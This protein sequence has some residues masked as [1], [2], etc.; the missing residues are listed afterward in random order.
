MNSIWSI[1]SAYLLTDM[2]VPKGQIHNLSGLYALCMSAK[3][4]LLTP[5]FC[6]SKWW[7]N[8][9][10]D[11]LADII[12]IFQQSCA[13]ILNLQYGRP[14]CVICWMKSWTD[15]HAGSRIQ[16]QLMSLKVE[17]RDINLWYKALRMTMMMHS[18]KWLA[19]S[20]ICTWLLR[21]ESQNRAVWNCRTLRGIFTNP[22]LNDCQGSF[23]WGALNKTWCGAI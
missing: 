22:A 8:G 15:S 5:A 12:S 20:V 4:R 3:D 13:V 6:S 7:W 16:L 19:F 23:A 18:W 21:G 11:W 17:Q 2:M 9:F 14:I 10:S 1:C